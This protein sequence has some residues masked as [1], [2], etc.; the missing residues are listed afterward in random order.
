MHND[1]STGKKC[2]FPGCRHIRTYTQGWA[3][4][5]LRRLGNHPNHVHTID[6]MFHLQCIKSLEE[7][8]KL[9]TVRHVRPGV[10]FPS[11]GSMKHQ[12]LHGTST[13]VSS[14]TS[15]IQSQHPNSASQQKI[16][17]KRIPFAN[18]L[19]KQNIC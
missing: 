9:T 17:G 15:K 4:Q 8:D 2:A 1:L 14:N 6:Y 19:N 12:D 10:G 3:L 18:L 16:Y 7:R 5:L 13:L 11:T